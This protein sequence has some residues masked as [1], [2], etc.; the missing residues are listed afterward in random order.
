MIEI[1]SECK[2]CVWFKTR[3]SHSSMLSPQRQR[4]SK[5]SLLPAP[6]PDR[7]A[8]QSPTSPALTPPRTRGWL[9]SCPSRSQAT[10]IGPNVA[11]FTRATISTWSV[12]HQ[13]VTLSVHTPFTPFSHFLTPLHLLILLSFIFFSFFLSF[14]FS[15]FCIF[16]LLFYF[17]DFTFLLLFPSVFSFLLSFP[18]IFF[19]FFFFFFLSFSSPFFPFP[20]LLF[21]YLFF[22]SFIHSL[23]F[24]FFLSP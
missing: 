3:S 24:S 7:R 19:L 9:K 6:P 21:P 10:P 23:S 2:S 22:L 1:L 15:S 16:F 17:L 11:A 4:R 13:G 14:I 5:T 8:P 12:R 18:S 20:F